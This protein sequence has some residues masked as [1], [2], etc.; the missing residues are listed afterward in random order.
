MQTQIERVKTALRDLMQGKMIILTDNP[1]RENEGDLIMA[2]EHVTPEAM[3]FIIRNGSGIVCVAMLPERLKELD[4]PLMVSAAENTSRGGTPFT[5]SVDANNG[6]TGVSAADRVRTIQILIDEKA[7]PSDLA[8]PGHIFPLQAKQGGVFARQGHTEGSVDLVTL[9]GCKPAAVLCEIM[10]EDGTMTRGEQLTEFA[11]QHQLTILSID[12]IIAY[13]LQHEYM[14]E[15]EATALFP[16][17]NYGEFKISVIKEKFT[18][19]EHVILFKEGKKA[20]QPALVR[21]HSSC[22]TGDLFSSQ[23]CDCNKQLHYSLQQISEEGGIL[24]YLSQ[25]GRGI[26][27]LNKIKAYALQEQGYDTVEA[28]LELGLPVDMRQYHIAASVLRKLGID[29]VRL[30]TNNPNK[31]N[32]LL[33]Y[34][35]KN[36]EKVAMPTFSQV[37]NHLYLQTKKTKLNH[38]IDLNLN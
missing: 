25:E 15:D 23:R 4:L 30:L 24:I 33:K 22:L 16:L 10:N 6:S 17:E 34:G 9:A 32:D 20:N 36:V 7:V 8:K 27:L 38:S 35:I 29:E 18:G 2:A 14:I 28:N 37:H 26:G 1:N 21:I 3:N 5:L 12:D 19:S 13:R 11:K 31:I